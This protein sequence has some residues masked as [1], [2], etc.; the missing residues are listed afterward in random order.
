MKVEGGGMGGK[1]EWREKEEEEGKGREVEKGVRGGRER[2]EGK[3][4]MKFECLG[5]RRTF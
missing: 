4:S 2:E 3:R 1:E 5:D